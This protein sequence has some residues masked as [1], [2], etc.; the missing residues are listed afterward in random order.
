MLW[1]SATGAALGSPRISTLLV[2]SHWP[3]F[4]VTSRT[5][6]LP[7][8]QL[9]TEV[10][11]EAPTPVPVMRVDHQVPQKL[12]AVSEPGSERVRDLV[13]V[14]LLDKGEDLDL[15]QVHAT[16]VRLFEYRR[17]QAWPP[18]V[19]SGDGWATLYEAAVEDIDVI[20][21]VEGAVA[22]VNEFVQRIATARG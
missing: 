5:R 16:C 15:A 9:F 7:D 4:V 13:D 19:V 17:Q 2:F 10:G 8:G 6:W 14:Q 21:H 3:G 18:T 1:R 11:L 22:W 12:N 20:P